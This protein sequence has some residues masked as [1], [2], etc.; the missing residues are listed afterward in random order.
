MGFSHLRVI[1]GVVFGIALV[2]TARSMAVAQNYEWLNPQSGAYYDPA[3]WWSLADGTSTVVPGPADSAFFSLNQSSPHTVAFSGNALLDSLMVRN[4]QVAFDLGGHALTLSRATDYLASLVIGESNGQ[5]GDLHL[6]NGI[7]E[8]QIST[9]GYL[10]GSV[11]NVSVDGAQW[12]NHR[13]M[14]VGSS[15]EG[16]LTISSGGYVESNRAIVGYRYGL[17]QPWEVEQQTSSGRIYSLDYITWA[18]NFA[19]NPQPPPPPPSRRDDV[20]DASSVATVTVDGATSTW[21][22]KNNLYVGPRHA[23]EYDSYKSVV[24]LTN[25][26]QLN[27]GRELQFSSRLGVLDT[28]GGRAVVGDADPTFDQTGTLYV[29]RGGTLSGVGYVDGDVVVA[30]GTVAVGREPK[31]AVDNEPLVISGDLTLSADSLLSLDILPRYHDQLVD[32]VQIGGIANLAG[33]LQID[34]AERF[35]TETHLPLELNLELG[36]ELTLLEFAGYTGQFDDVIISG[37]ESDDRRLLPVYHDDNLSLVMS[38][39][40]DGDANGDNLVDGRDF[41]A[42]ASAFGAADVERF[43]P[44]SVPYPDDGDYNGDGVI[45]GQDYAVWEE[46]LDQYSIPPVPNVTMGAAGGD[47]NHD[48]V[49]DG[50]DY[51]IWASNFNAPGAE[52]PGSA[53]VSAATPEPAA[54]LLLAVGVGIVTVSRRRR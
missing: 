20:A 21:N 39:L 27:V 42:W 54:A 10:Q 13:L 28:R 18:G 51:L 26:G 4:D 47:F 8:S 25:G 7:L 38:T 50:N 9:I 30:G 53:A 49:V 22:V 43:D 11:G 31:T 36:S 5:R 19:S 6:A 45:D 29:G 35:S 37:W 23:W 41:V 17:P 33:T 40:I 3:N 44:Y 52:I 12:I 34:V 1:R 32:G 16:S 48:G 14:Q 2:L 24:E 15:G 46:I